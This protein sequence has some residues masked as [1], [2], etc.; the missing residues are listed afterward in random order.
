MKPFHKHRKTI[1][2]FAILVMVASLWMPGAPAQADDVPVSAVVTPGSTPPTI[3]WKWELPDMQSG[4][5]GIQYGTAADVHQHDDD[6]NISPTNPPS[7]HRMMQMAPNLEDLPEVRQIEYWVAVQDAGGV[8]DITDAFV[9]VYHPD[10]TLKYQL[11]GTGNYGP[12]NATNRLTPVACSAL[13]DATSVG[14][15]LEAAVHSG[16]MTAAE[17]F[18]IVDQC[19]KHQKLVFRMVGELSKHQPAG[20]YRVEATGVDQAGS[21]GSMTNWFDVLPVIGLRIDFNSVNFGQILPNTPKW[22]PGDMN[23]NGPS[24]TRPTVKNVGNSQMKLSLLFSKMTGF[25]FGKVISDF[26]AQLDSEQI[27]VITAGTAVTFTHTLGSNQLG[28]LDLSIHPGSIPADSYSG[29]L[30]LTGSR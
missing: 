4:I 12:P 10:G 3:E 29:M 26:D 17:A 9:K 15:V 14:T 8:S 1:A 22:V 13:G 30:S 23:F 16:Q 20:E 21:T 27:P 28:Q 11:H 25:N 2:V 5:P 7:A 24:D 19:N 18:I 6:M